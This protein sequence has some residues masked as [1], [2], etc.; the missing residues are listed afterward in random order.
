[1]DSL[2]D[3]QVEMLDFERQWWA[4]PGRKEDAIVERFGMSPVRYYQR[5]AQLLAAPAAL[6]YDP[7]TANRLRRITRE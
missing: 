1:M 3:Q 7:V 2:T 5:L 6:A 4:T